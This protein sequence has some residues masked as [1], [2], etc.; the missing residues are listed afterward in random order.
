MR[1][2]VISYPGGRMPRLVYFGWGLGTL[3]LASFAVGS[4]LLL[5][6][7]T[8]FMAVPPAV[9]GMIFAAAKLYD[10]II[11]PL[12]GGITDRTRSRWG[13]RRPYML[14]G[15][16]ACGLIF[17]LAF[18]APVVE[19]RSTA[20]I[21]LAFLL[22][23]HATAYTTFSVPYMA[24]PAEITDDT[25]ERSKLMSFR[26]INGALGNL[27]GGFGTASLIAFFGGGLVGHRL[28]G[29]AVGLFIFFALFACF[30]LTSKA[31]S[32]EVGTVVSMSYREMFRSAATNRPFIILQAA[33]LMLLSAAGFHT[34]SAAFFVQRSLQK[35]DV[36]LGVI[37]A[38]LTVGTVISQPMWLFLVRTQGKRM[39][40]CGGGVFTALTW[41]AWF[42]FGAGT[43][44]WVV[45]LI[46][47]LAGIGNGGIVMVSQSML[48][49]TIEYQYRTTGMRIAG[50][51]AGLY[52]MIEKFGIAI[53]SSLV[54]VT[55]GLF[56]YIESS[57]GVI[58]EQPAS[59]VLGISLS[60]SV[61]A[62]VFLL[63]SVAIMWHYPLDERN[64]SLRS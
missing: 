49:D 14:A 24:M 38:T 61:L 45:I 33:K 20:V 4:F 63:A 35:S 43:P 54:G 40:F 39:T 10:G 32:R 57:A 51:F 60:Y 30:M 18:N 11:D 8:D 17:M 2:P 29:V 36:W 22:V 48:P 28:M 12:A 55:L 6:F 3:G 1:E 37:F 15:A 21:M 56:G 58:V 26:V 41:L 52:V 47:T 9:A 25:H 7:M 16:F 31:R 42:P 53:G 13:R 34:A 19:S 46:G 50:S 62:T 59:A 44:G 23:L 27:V 5:R 64:M